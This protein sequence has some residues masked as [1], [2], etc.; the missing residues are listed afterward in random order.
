MRL[1]GGASAAP[2]KSGCFL[3]IFDAPWARGPKRLGPPVSPAT[4]HQEPGRCGACIGDLW[5]RCPT[6]SASRLALLFIA[7]ERQRGPVGF[8]HGGREPVHMGGNRIETRDEGDD[9]RADLLGERGGA[10]A[11][12]ANRLIVVVEN[13][14][15]VPSAFVARHHFTTRSLKRSA[16]RPSSFF[17]TC[18]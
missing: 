15:P 4:L 12:F 14:L 7:R 6:S 3:A 5:A 8:M 13:Q 9:Q 16:R 1:A 11:G 10:A 18:R 17:A 2:Q